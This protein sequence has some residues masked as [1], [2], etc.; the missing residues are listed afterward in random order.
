MAKRILFQG[1]STEDH[2]SAVEHVLKADH[3]TRVV[4]SVAFMNAR[5]LSLLREDIMPIARQT[6]ILT[7]IRN[8]I[9]SAQ[10][11]KTSLEMGCSTYAVDTGSRKLVFHPKIYLSRNPNEARL[12]VGSANLTFGGLISNI[13]ASI[14]LTLDLNQSDDKQFVERL[15]NQ[16]DAMIV[17]FPENVLHIA[18]IVAIE[19][20]LVSGRVIDENINQGPTTTGSSRRR[21]LDSTPRMNLKTRSIQLPAVNPFRQASEEEET[22]TLATPVGVLAPV[23]ERLALVWKSNPPLLVDHQGEATQRMLRQTEPRR[24]YV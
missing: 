8:G 4:M 21:S 5:G 9:T 7:G 10:G 6:T 22:P 1:L 11:L 19:D 3:P 13:E 17:E 14:L 12:L 23:S 16:I 24:W 20:L 18:D 2:L 15:E